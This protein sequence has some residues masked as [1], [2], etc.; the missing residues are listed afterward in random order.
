MLLASRV[1]PGSRLSSSSGSSGCPA[2]DAR[3]RPEAYVADKLLDRSVSS[4]ETGYVDERRTKRDSARSGI[5][6]MLDRFA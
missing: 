6:S 5:V 1:H 3:F 2:I 4:V